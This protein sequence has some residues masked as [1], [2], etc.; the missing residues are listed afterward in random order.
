MAQRLFVRRRD[1]RVEVRLNESGRAVARETVAR[2]MAAQSDPTHDWYASLSAPMDPSR[3]VDDPIATLNRQSEVTTNAELCAATLDEEFL[4]DAEVWAWLCTF[5]VALRGTITAAG[6]L[7]DDR[8]A[9][10]E[11]ELRE[12]ITT[13]QMFLFALADVM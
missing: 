12:R 13:L 10:A 9:T 3:D 7:T 4:T 6:V 1:G 2:V 11:S 5:Q 8:L